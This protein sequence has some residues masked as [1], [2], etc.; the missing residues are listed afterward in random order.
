MTEFTAEIEKRYGFRVADDAAPLAGGQENA[1]FRISTSHGRFA[2]RVCAEWIDSARVAAEHAVL[3]FMAGRLPEVHAP[4]SALDG[5]TWFQQEG[6]AVCVFPLVRGRSVSRDDDELRLLS[7]G[8]LARIHTAGLDYAGRFALPPLAEFDWERN[9]FW[10]LGRVREVIE[11]LAARDD[12]IAQDFA[13]A[14]PRIEDEQRWARERLSF[15]TGVSGVVQGDYWPGNV[16]ASGGR[17]TGV[18]DWL[19]SRRDLL[20]VELGRAVWEFCSHREDHTLVRDRAKAFLDSYH[21]AGGPGADVPG[22][23][24]DAMRVH[25]LADMLHDL[26]Y[27]DPEEAAAYHLGSLHRIEHLASAAPLELP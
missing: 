3:T 24:I 18:I 4:L 9:P 23:L 6:R 21:A 26:T 8:L 11:R 5:S 16:L 22:V 20:V 14:A 7:A 12:S 25:V 2:V 19:E 1:I 13:A 10:D 15:M 17:I 27:T